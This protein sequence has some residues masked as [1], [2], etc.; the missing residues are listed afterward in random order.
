[1]FDSDPLLVV[2]HLHGILV[3]ALSGGPV[4]VRKD[5]DIFGVLVLAGTTA[6]VAGSCATY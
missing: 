2:L 3:F 6:L 4:V 1:M 5:L